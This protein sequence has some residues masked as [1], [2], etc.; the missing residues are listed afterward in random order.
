MSSCPSDGST[1]PKPLP[2]RRVYHP[3]P[4]GFCRDNF[5]DSGVTWDTPDLPDF[6]TCF[7]ST[8]L[9]WVPCIFLWIFLPLQLYHVR[10]RPYRIKQ[11]TWIS[12]SKMTLALTLAAISLTDMFLNMASWMDEGAANPAVADLLQDILGLATYLLVAFTV[13]TDKRRARASSG[14]LFFFWLLTLICTLITCR[15]LIQSA[16]DKGVVE[17]GIQFGL[18]IIY[19]LCVIAQFVLTF[20]GEKFAALKSGDKNPCPAQYASFPSELIFSWLSGLVYKGWKKPLDEDDLWSTLPED[21]TKLNVEILEKHWKAELQRRDRSLAAVRAGKTKAKVYEPSLTKALWKAYWSPL[22]FSGLLR[23]IN[24]LSIFVSPQ[25]LSKLIDFVKD[26]DEPGWKGYLYAILLLMSSC[27]QTIILNYYLNICMRIGMHVRGSVVAEVYRKALL[28]TSE[29]KRS[30]N[31]GEIVNLMSVDAQRFMDFMAYIHVLWSGPL[32]MALAIY[33][34]SQ[35]VSVSVVAGVATLVLLVPLQGF[36]V[37][38]VKGLQVVQMKEKDSRIKMMN[39]ILNGM[40]VLKL[41]AWEASF[42]NIVATIR[43]RELSTLRKAANFGA[44]AYFTFIA[45]PFFVALATFATYVLTDETNVLNKKKAF[46]ALSLL[47]ILR[48]PLTLLPAAITMAL[49]VAVSIKRLSKFLCNDE[50]DAG[51]VSAL[52]ASSPSS[53]VMKNATFSWSKEGPPFLNNLQLNIKQ[54]SLVAVVGHV[55][56]GKSSLCSALLGLMEKIGGDVAIKGKIGYVPQQAWIQNLTLRDNILFGKEYQPWRYDKTLDTCSLR[57]DLEMLSA[58]DRTEIGERGT[59]LSGGQRQRISLARAVYSDADVFILDDPLSAVDAHVGKHIFENVIGPHGMLCGKT[60]LLVTHGVSFL[61]QTDLIIV[62]DNG[63]ISEMGTYHQLLRNRGVFADFLRTYLAEAET[64]EEENEEDLDV[65]LIKE[66]LIKEIGVEY[67]NAARQSI[68]P[69]LFQQD[70]HGRS[71]SVISTGTSL[72]ASQKIREVMRRESRRPSSIPG[73]GGQVRLRRG[74]SAKRKSETLE[75]VEVREDKGRLVESEKSET[76]GVKWS[77]YFMLIRMM[78]LPTVIIMSIFYAI[79][80]GSNV[81]SNFWLAA[82]AE[83]SECLP[84][85]TYISKEQRDYR[86]GIYAAFGISQGIFILLA[87]FGLARARIQASRKSHERMLHRIM[88]APMAFFDTTPLGRIVNRFSKDIDTIDISI[89]SNLEV[90]LYCLY[91]VISI[92][93]VICI[94]TPPFAVILLPLGAFYYFMQRYFIATSRQ[95][96]RLEAVS[97]SPI[98]SHFQESVAGS[99]VIWATKQGP[100]FVAENERRVDHNNAAYYPNMASQRW[101]AVRLEFVGICVT[102]FSAMFAVL[103]HEYPALGKVINAQQIGLSISYSLQLT[104]ILNWFVRMASELESNVVSVERVKE[105]SEITTEAAWELEGSRPPPDWPTQGQV[106]L[107]NY[108]TRYRPELDLVLKGV[109]ADI[110]PGEKIGIVGRTGAGKSSLTLALFR[111]IEASEGAILIDG[112]NIANIGLHDVR[113]RITILP[114]E[115]VLFSGSLRLNLDPF[116]RFSDEEV[117]LALENSHLKKFVSALPQGLSHTVADGGENYS[118]G[119]RQLI[120]LARAL[121]RKTKILVL[122]E[123]TA[124]IDLETDDLIQD[125]ISEKFAD[126]TILTIAHRINTIMDS[127]RIMVLD[128]G[129]VKEFESPAELLK[130]PNGIF[131]S[132]AKTANLLPNSASSDKLD[133]LNDERL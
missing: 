84:E 46:V 31:V 92:V 89:P 36:I 45:S 10:T 58:G 75:K 118:V 70:T 119:Q 37:V 43:G 68:A 122:D 78:G 5:W 49:Q 53:V 101:I 113:S 74:T 27:T 11:W 100:R 125:T 69:S 94:N 93:L 12:V 98:Y 26:P 18:Y 54:G 131:Y 42:Q 104:Q 24:D 29:A 39:E 64:I 81:G 41:Y 116:N 114:Q 59:N 87:A 115:P 129:R 55:G 8:V 33:F 88:R 20:Y 63:A 130:D 15:S 7:Q 34:L 60:R 80:Y 97:R 112:I 85:G 50:L 51:I 35:L 21:R 4:D 86:L 9:I 72:A 99:S 57:K 120:C 16:I 76:G 95:L 133:Q 65:D 121:L 52:E 109:D 62:L 102:F 108:Q 40:K 128:Q 117:W 66:E 67:L 105:Y 111:I 30:S 3:F 38:K 48:L 79:S 107:K 103:G 61:P 44:V 28:I 25:L 13:F 90:W 2:V 91:S 22:V 71:M 106:Q 73:Q 47:N 126:C 19:T 77:V 110:L 32:Q 96:K 132:L 1:A 82:W 6:T 124:A 83:D 123:A 14:P 56:S 23:V 127:T 17:R